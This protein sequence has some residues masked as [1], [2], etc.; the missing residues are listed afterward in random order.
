MAEEKKRK[1]WQVPAYQTSGNNKAEV[2]AWMKQ[3]VD[4][5]LEFLQAS[6]GYQQLE[7]SIRILSGRPTKDLAE[8]QDEGYSTLN[9]NHLKRNIREMVNAL[10]EIRYNPG[11]LSKNNDLKPTA[12]L[13][14]NVGYAW[15]IDQFIDL[16]LKKAV[17]WCAISPCGWL[18][19]CNRRFPGDH[20]KAEIDAIPY[21]YF[22]VVMTGVPESGDH[23][24]AYTV[25]IIKDLPIYLA[26]A[27]WPDHTKILKPDRET[28]KGWAERIKDKAKKIMQDVF[29]TEPELSTAKNP[30]CRLYYQYVLDLS[31]NRTGKTMKMGYE[32]STVND[33]S[34]VNGKREELLPMPWSYDVP[35]LGQMV[36]RGYRFNEQSGKDEPYYT[37]AAHD[38]CRI[39]PGRRLLVGNDEDLIYDGPM[40]DWHG[41]VPLVKFT[42]DSWPFGEFSML[43][44]ATPIHEA[45]NEIYRVGHQTVRNRFNPTLLY[46]QRAIDKPRANS[47]RADIQG[48]RVGYNGGEV[49]DA[50]KAIDT[51][52]TSEF[53]TIE[54]WIE[55]LQSKLTEEEDFITGRPN[56]AAL[57]KMKM[58][59]TGDNTENVL[60]EA[61][62]IV[63]G[64]S[65]DMERSMRD[66]ADMFK[67]LVIQ[68]K[69]TPELMWVV[70]VDQM[71]PQSFDFQPGN[72]IPAHLPGEN[73]KYKS[74]Y[75]EM[76]RAR[77]IADKIP[78]LLM[79][80][81][82][83]EI[84]QTQQ[85]MIYMQLWAK[86]FPI[87]PVTLGEVLRLGNVGTIEGSTMIE[88]W[89]NWKK[90]LLE[91]E[92]ALKQAAQSMI[93]EEAGGQNANAMNTGPKGGQKG[94]GGRASSGGQSPQLAQKGDGRVVTKESK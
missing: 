66:F 36:M 55:K 94:T 7:E 5:G 31:I 81:T 70:G 44:D 78:F 85:K 62:P 16:K 28:P 19:I 61:G 86:G 48:D 34:A 92:V 56:F 20:G 45:V 77:W 76:Q 43:Y 84:V 8:K 23:Q 47:L 83:H 27:I 26:H 58:A 90:K 59:V 52:F 57:S 64:I 35:S 30:T 75:T 22:D 50:R 2:H 51:L 60:N 65:R 3:N 42:A 12:E 15:Y 40:F 29:S 17:Q 88:R 24:E 4:D 71:T 63:K 87:D 33:P 32:K 13:L 93:G 39:F 37:P 10:S 72:L 68:Y 18:E 38:E 25:T 89:F 14:N 74:V 11:Y 9:V 79:P 54:G 6:P 46:N 73:T 1:Q 69:R 82:M 91:M 21:S 80:G 49:S 41:K 67:Y 53:N